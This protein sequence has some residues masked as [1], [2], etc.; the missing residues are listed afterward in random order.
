[1]PALLPQ[2]EHI[3]GVAHLDDETGIDGSRGV[4]RLREVMVS[5][6]IEAMAERRLKMINQSGPAPLPGELLSLSA[7]DQV[8]IYRQTTKD[9]PSWVGPV[10]VQH[11]DVEHN[12]V[13][14]T[15]QNRTLSV[16][17]SSIRRAMIFAT[18]HF[19]TAIY[20]Y[21][22]HEHLATQAVRD[23]L[24]AIHTWSILLGWIKYHDMW[25]TT[26]ESRS[27]WNVLVALLFF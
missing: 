10:T 27:H 4:H 3:A 15:W 26:K 23:A 11:A 1:M 25:I 19:D 14:V 5:S 8:E 18:F 6:M 22:E 20:A 2:L 24:E 16:P 21:P 9:R 17:L 13:T 7:G 12:K